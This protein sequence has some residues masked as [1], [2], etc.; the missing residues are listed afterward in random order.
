MLMSSITVSKGQL[1]VIRSKMAY[2]YL[3]TALNRIIL[4]MSSANERIALE[5]SKWM[6]EMVLGKPRQVEED[7]ASDKE[8]ALLLAKTLRQVIENTSPHVID[9]VHRG[10]LNSPPAVEE[11][12]G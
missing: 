7:T 3:P 9:V 8:T 4:A 2:D 6:A 1:A 12:D 10:I 11:F 5:A